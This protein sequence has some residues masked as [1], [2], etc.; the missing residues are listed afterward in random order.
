MRDHAVAEK[1]IHAMA[2]AIEELVGDHEIQRLVFFLQRSHGGNGN[3]A[4]DAQLLEA[5]NI[6]AKI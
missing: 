4:L 5:V 6:G 1:S 3:D 2:G